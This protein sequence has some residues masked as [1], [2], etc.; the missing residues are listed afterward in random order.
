MHVDNV[1]L[2]FL[3]YN[4][5]TIITTLL[6]FSLLLSFKIFILFLQ[7]SISSLDF[8]ILVASV[9]KHENKIKVPK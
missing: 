6:V 1:T 7:I 8:R 9:L 3:P 4:L 5:L 2:S